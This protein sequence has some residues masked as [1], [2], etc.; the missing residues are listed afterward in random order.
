MSCYVVVCFLSFVDF[1]VTG[2]MVLGN[3]VE[4]EQHVVI[5]LMSMMCLTNVLLCTL[6]FYRC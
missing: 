2:C 4:G 1:E 3:Q 5:V 6:L